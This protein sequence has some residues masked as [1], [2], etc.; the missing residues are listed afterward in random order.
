LSLSFICKKISLFF[1]PWQ[2]KTT[3]YIF[4]VNGKLIQTY[5]AK[6]GNS[7]YPFNPSKGVYVI[8]LQNEQHVFVKKEVVY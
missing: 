2:N 6:E 5:T 3:I 8:K 4:D 1:N 7:N